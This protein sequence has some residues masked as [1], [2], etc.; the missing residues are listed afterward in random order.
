MLK[1]SSIRVGQGS[2]PQM[3]MPAT[4]RPH[5]Y[6]MDVDRF[7]R[8]AETAPYR[9][10]EGMDALD[11]LC[12]MAARPQR[13]CAMQALAEL[14]VERGGGNVPEEYAASAFAQTVHRIGT[15][16]DRSGEL[17][18][19][20]AFHLLAGT[21]LKEVAAHEDNTRM[22]DLFASLAAQGAIY[23]LLLMNVVDQQRSFSIL[24]KR[25]YEDLRE[26]EEAVEEMAMSILETA[27]RSTAH[28][29][30]HDLLSHIAFHDTAEGRVVRKT[31]K[32][33]HKRTIDAPMRS[34]FLD[35]RVTIPSSI[36]RRIAK[37]D[38]PLSAGIRTFLD[39][40]RR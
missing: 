14:V 20:G 7:V 3:Q 24:D 35:G 5:A 12:R 34:T 6:P 9:S 37:D 4:V 25:I 33:E 2:T 19:K 16:N 32:R 15:L 27:I 17:F 13:S 36:L 23:P 22:R 21:M 30:T 10:I 11:E 31:L 18:A 28:R 8:I 26:N 1:I 40:S 39:S 38:S 29:P